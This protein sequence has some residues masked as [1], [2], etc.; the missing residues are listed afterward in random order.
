MDVIFTTRAWKNVSFLSSKSEF[1]S[2]LT[3]FPSSMA[4]FPYRMYFFISSVKLRYKISRQ[5]AYI[6]AHFSC[7]VYNQQVI[8]VTSSR[9]SHS[10]KFCRLELEVPPN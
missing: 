2:S 9:P 4:Y 3:K 1:L 6:I 8:H 10:L 5:G 7:H